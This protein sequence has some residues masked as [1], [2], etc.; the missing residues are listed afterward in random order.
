ML[1]ADQIVALLNEALSLD[2]AAIEALFA[3]RVACNQKIEDH[4]TIVVGDPMNG[5]PASL[6]VLG[7]L[8]GIVG[9]DGMRIHSHHPD[10]HGP[11]MID[12]FELRPIPAEVAELPAPPDMTVWSTLTWGDPE[13]AVRVLMP[14]HHSGRIEHIGPSF[15]Q[16]QIVKLVGSL[17]TMKAFCKQFGDV[18]KA[19]TN[20]FTITSPDGVAQVFYHAVFTSIE[21]LRHTRD[22]GC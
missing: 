6:G 4:P 21:P 1:T 20:R 13:V 14:A 12:K 3:H 9:L 8:N 10:Y 16:W 22:V 2:K 15:Q 11:D 17:D 19:G 7:L 18:T 5:M